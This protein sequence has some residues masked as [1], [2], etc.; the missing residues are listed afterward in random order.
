MPSTAPITAATC[1]FARSGS[2]IVTVFQTGAGTLTTQRHGH[3]IGN[4]SRKSRVGS[5]EKEKDQRHQ[6]LRLLQRR[7]LVSDPA[8]TKVW[9]PNSLS[10]TIAAC[11]PKA[12]KVYFYGSVRAH[13]TMMARID[14]SPSPPFEN[15]PIYNA[16]TL[17]WI[18]VRYAIVRHHDRRL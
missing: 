14:F 1:K 18:K 9:L 10:R 13:A 5:S 4:G 17:T 11:P 15:A 2:V 3:L 6:S 12:P 8:V 16:Q 7:Q